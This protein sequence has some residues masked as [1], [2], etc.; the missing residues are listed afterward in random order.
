MKPQPSGGFEWVQAMG[1]PA[2][3]CVALRP[4]ANHLFTTRGWALGCHAVS[5]DEDWQP[6]AASLG[7]D[8]AHLVRLH[9]VHGA[10]VEV[11]RA[12][13]RQ[14]PSPRPDADIVVC[15]D[16]S[17]ALAIQTADCVPILI[18]DRLTGAVAAA[19]AGWRGLAAGVP[20]AAVGALTREF[21]GAPA[22]LIAAVGPSISA[23][24]YEVGEDVH[25]RFLAAGFPVQQIARWFRPAERPDHWF[26]DGWQSVH[27]QLEAA[28][29]APTD[30]HAAGLCT[31]TYP[32]LFCSYRRDGKGAGRIAAAIR[33]SHAND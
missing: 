8:A 1:G 10:A 9:Q 18:A 25:A 28:G 3:V 5:A 11:R 14:P 32:D 27:D 2:L 4:F 16:P 29:L 17:I 21:G 26:F 23:E 6:V 15:D 19:H 12:R 22:D 13:D 33:S 7:V 24:R 31:A 20:G 30:I